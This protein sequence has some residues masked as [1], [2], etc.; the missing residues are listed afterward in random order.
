MT[1]L[2]VISGAILFH[3]L[4]NG[5]MPVL[6]GQALR[7]NARVKLY[8]IYYTNVLIIKIKPSRCDM[9]TSNKYN[10]LQEQTI[11]SATPG[12][13]LKMICILDCNEKPL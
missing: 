10:E 2:H 12:Q 7:I 11:L 1:R 3:N 9:D 6:I 4:V 13:R 8:L 5:L